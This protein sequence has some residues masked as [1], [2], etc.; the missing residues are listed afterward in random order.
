MWE[1]SWEDSFIF[2]KRI[3]W[4]WNPWIVPKAR[5]SR[6]GTIQGTWCYRQNNFI[7]MLYAVELG[8]ELQN[9][10]LYAINIY[11]YIYLSCNSSAPDRWME[12]EVSPC[13][14]SSMGL[15]PLGGMPGCWAP[16]IICNWGL[17]AKI[18]AGQTW[19]NQLVMFAGLCSCRFYCHD[20]FAIKRNKKDNNWIILIL[21]GI[22]DNVS[23]L[24]FNLAWA[25]LLQGLP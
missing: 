3:L 10:S 13:R 24:F 14:G 4:R 22:L 8:K 23:S 5:H 21:Y 7:S 9:N 6:W 16:G 11:I 20:N 12:T 2:T 1:W 25:Q 15:P 19:I 18:D 17:A